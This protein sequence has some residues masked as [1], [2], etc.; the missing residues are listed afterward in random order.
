MIATI[1]I[2]AA[3]LLIA[4]IGCA[5]VKPVAPKQVHP[6]CDRSRRSGRKTAFGS[7]DAVSQR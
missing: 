2:S 6:C 3:A 5:W 1:L 7:D 4:V